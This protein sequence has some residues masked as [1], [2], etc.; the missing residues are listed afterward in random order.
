M[1]SKYPALKTI[2]VVIRVMGW[3]FVAAGMIALVSG[4]ILLLT[5]LASGRVSIYTLYAFGAALF[6]GMWGTL[7]VAVGGLIPL[8]IDIEQNTRNQ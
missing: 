3:T 5:S 8:F 7:M 4:L 2:S 6:G 1:D